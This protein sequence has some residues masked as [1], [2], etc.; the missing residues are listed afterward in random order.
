MLT[1]LKVFGRGILVTI[2]LPFI[3]LVLAL[4]LVYCLLLFV[5][6]FFRG[7]I[8]FFSG[9]NIGSELPEDLEAKRIVLENEKSDAQAKDMLNMMY[10]GMAQSMAQ[11]AFN[12][13]QQQQ[14]PQIRPDV[15][16]YL[17][18]NEN[19]EAPQEI[20]Q[21]EMPQGEDK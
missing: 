2:L 16:D 13:A 11:A 15:I 1:F 9:G 8:A 19:N 21:Q 20:T 3:L 14:Q 12:Q 7:V 5:V 17:T 4:Y 10:Q 6:M 18:A